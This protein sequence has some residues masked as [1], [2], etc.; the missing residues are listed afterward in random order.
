MDGE[1]EAGIPG[2]EEELGAGVAD[3]DLA[4]EARDTR[5]LGEGDGVANQQGAK[6][7]PSAPQVDTQVSD[8]PGVAS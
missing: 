1:A 7:T 4:G 8:V 2:R 3:D 5:A 6:A